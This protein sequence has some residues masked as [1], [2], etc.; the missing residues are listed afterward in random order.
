M[1]KSRWEQIHYLLIV[2][3]TGAARGKN[4]P[5]FLSLENLRYVS[6]VP[7][8]AVARIIIQDDLPSSERCI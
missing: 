8:L 2:R 1:V 3:R 6:T 5:W 4:H 7:S